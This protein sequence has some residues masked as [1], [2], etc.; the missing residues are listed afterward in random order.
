MAYAR[1]WDSDLYIY[2]HIN[3]YIYCAGCQLE[4]HDDQSLIKHLDKHKRA[5]DEMPSNLLDI[6]LED[7][8]R[9]NKYQDKDNRPK[10]TFCGH[11]ERIA[12]HQEQ[13]E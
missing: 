7:I 12:M 3:G 10:Y 4:I 9:Y 1:F 11:C 6:I 8:D 5:G 13:E 2:S